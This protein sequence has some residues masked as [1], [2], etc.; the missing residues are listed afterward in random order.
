MLPVNKFKVGYTEQQQQELLNLY[1]HLRSLPDDY[2]GI[3]VKGGPKVPGIVLQPSQFDFP[4][5][6]F[7]EQTFPFLEDKCSFIVTDNITS[8]FKPH[9]D[10]SHGSVFTV[11][12]SDNT[13]VTTWY[14]INGVPAHN[15]TKDLY[16]VVAHDTA[17][18]SIRHTEILTQGNTYL[19][20][21]HTF[22]SVKNVTQNR[23]I[24][25][26]W[27]LRH[28]AYQ[29]ALDYCQRAGLIAL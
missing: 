17:A 14:T 19:F 16:G 21:S 22:H 12:E 1:W 27:W 25:F 5:L 13:T 29:P 3:L 8:E 10:T 2:P 23:R 7:A 28:I 24:I 26:T 18:L 11:L 20:D 9:S 6:R 4:I 15:F